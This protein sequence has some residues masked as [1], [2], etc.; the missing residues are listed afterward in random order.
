MVPVSS[1][2]GQVVV[3]DDVAVLTLHDGHGESRIIKPSPSQSL[4]LIARQPVVSQTEH[5]AILFAVRLDYCL[6]LLKT[7]VETY[8]SFVKIG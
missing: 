6:V 1:H 4:H 3:T 2:S 7:C 8:S 5:G